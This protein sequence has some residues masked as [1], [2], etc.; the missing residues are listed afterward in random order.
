MSNKPIQYKLIYNRKNQLNSK[1]E[2]IIQIEAYKDAKRVYFSTGVHVKPEHWD[3]KKDRIIKRNDSHQLNNRLIKLIEDYKDLEYAQMRDNP[4]FG[5]QELKKALQQSDNEYYIEFALSYLDKE[6]NLTKSTYT[7]YLNS[8]NTFK[9]Y[10]KGD[11]KFS[12][13]NFNLVDGFRLY[14]IEKGVGVNTQKL[15]FRHL[16]KYAKTAVSYGYLPYTSNPFPNIIIKGEKAIRYALDEAE[17]KKLEKLKFKKAEKHLEVIRDMF[18]F[19]CYTGLRFSDVSRLGAEHI[20]TASDGLELRMK[21]EK[22]SKPIDLP[23]Y[24]LHPVEGGRSKPEQIL[25][26]YW[27]ED[28]KPFFLSLKPQQ[29]KAANNQYANRE[30]KVIQ[31]MAGVRT[32]LTN[33]VGRHTFATFLIW[34]LP[35]PIVQE[36][37]QHSKI[38]T[39]M[40]YIHVGSGKVK[41][42][43]K[44]ITDWI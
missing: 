44:K 5:V 22:S 30:L 7:K 15:Y 14:L 33:H 3:S 38:D 13:L 28:D 31:E 10:V 20:F 43:L 4:S 40:A 41:Q 1:G 34:R 12:E 8:I 25:E 29:S 2:G 18:L 36:L 26:K 24:L 42:H 17:I 23:L 32:K 6:K 35:L 21:A 27:R 11:V 37:L 9:E 19:T 39:T 16:G